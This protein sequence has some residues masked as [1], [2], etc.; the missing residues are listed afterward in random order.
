[1]ARIL[2]MRGEESVI[3]LERESEP[4]GLCRSKKVGSHYLDIGG[5]HFLCSRHQRVYDFIFSHIPETEFNRHERVSKIQLGEDVIDYPVESNIWQL[6]R[7]KAQAYLDSIGGVKA[8]GPTNFENWIQCRL[9]DRI[10][11]DYMIPYNRKIWG[12]EP[13]ELDVDWLQK[14]PQMNVDEIRRSVEERRGS[15]EKFPSHA[16]F[17]Y[18]KSG[19]FQELFD[20]ICEPVRSKVVLDCPVT[21]IERKGA[22]WVVNGEYVAEKVISTI[23]WRFVFDAMVDRPTHLEG[24]LDR[25]RHTTLVVSLEERDYD[26]EAHWKYIPAL[27]VEH[28]R[29]FYIH[30]F[31]PHSDPRGVYT[32]TNVKRWTDGAA[33][34]SLTYHENEFAYPIPVVGHAY[35]AEAIRDHFTGMGFHSVGRW[36]QW[37]FFN[38]DVC[39]EEAFKLAEVI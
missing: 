26:H 28:H 32:E 29:E 35:A 18:P 36:G 37:K 24:H 8:S 12:V 15:P 3:V 6:P 27:E 19:G 39:I 4:G 38:S 23:P 34:R 11:D 7:D 20:A 30:N 1:M 21:R 25:L 9:G 13:S 5:G 33:R 17:F 31:A 22:E 14:I 10:A 16:H 2:Q